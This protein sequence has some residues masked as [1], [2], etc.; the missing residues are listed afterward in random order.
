MPQRTKAAKGE[1][2]P[3]YSV[4]GTNSRYYLIRPFL[5][6]ILCACIFSLAHYSQ[7]PPQHSKMAATMRMSRSASVS[8]PLVVKPTASLKATVQKVAQFAGVSIASLVRSFICGKT[9]R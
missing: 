1:S 7:P 9:A 6:E 3:F 5:L 2:H 8:R 4:I